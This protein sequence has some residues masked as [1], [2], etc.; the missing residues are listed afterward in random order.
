MFI[1]LLI[2]LLG[3][4][5]STFNNTIPV[6]QKIEFY[7][8]DREANVIAARGLGGAI[9]LSPSPLFLPSFS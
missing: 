8:G 7:K 5:P 2:A 1:Y 3:V 4:Y 6:S 9:R